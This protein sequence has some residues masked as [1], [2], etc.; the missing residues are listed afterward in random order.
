[1]MVP[2]G[3]PALPKHFEYETEVLQSTDGEQGIFLNWFQKK[4]NQ[5]KRALII[6]HG[7]GEHGGRYQHFVHY[8]QDHYDLFLAPDLRG[9]G[10]SEG[11][12]G[13]VESFDEYVDD[14]LL[15]FEALR[16]RLGP[17]AHVDWF[18]HSMGGTVTLRALQYRSKLEVDR[19]IFSAP[20]VKLKVQ[21]PLVKDLAARLLARVWG[22]LTLGTDLDPKKLSHDPQVVQ[23][24]LKDQLHHTKATP[25]FYLSFLEAME[26]IQDPSFQFPSQSKLLFQFA[27]EDEIVDTDAGRAFYQSLRHEAKEE[28]VYKG[29]FHEIY[30]EVAKEDVFHDLIRFLESKGVTS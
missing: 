28:I 14:A 12:R 16:S 9:H 20:C 25:Q 5:A 10:R 8:L 24:I 23:A 18:S 15:A 21:V 2:V 1:M 11:V 4:N 7:Q 6:I 13:H 29:L 17:D 3:F 27:G 26:R 22:S 30:N 19:F